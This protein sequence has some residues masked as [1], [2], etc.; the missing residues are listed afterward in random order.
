LVVKATPWR[1]TTGKE[2]QYALYRRLG[3]PQRR[4]GWVG[5]TSPLLRFDPQTVQLVASSSTDQ[6]PWIIVPLIF[7][8]YLALTTLASFSLLIPEVT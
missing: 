3:D 7:F 4:S 5:K 2:T 8:F 1:F 6:L